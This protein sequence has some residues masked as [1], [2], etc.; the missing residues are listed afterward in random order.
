MSRIVIVSLIPPC[1]HNS[2][3]NRR[4]SAFLQRRQRHG[5]VRRSG[6]L[7]AVVEVRFPAGLPAAVPRATATPLTTVAVVD[8]DLSGIPHRLRSNLFNPCETERAESSYMQP[9]EIELPPFR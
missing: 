9:A 1:Q 3:R 6:A 4:G 8:H 2:K 5:R 7:Q